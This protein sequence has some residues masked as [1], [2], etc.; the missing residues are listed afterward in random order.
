MLFHYFIEYPK[1]QEVFKKTNLAM[2]LE[3]TFSH[4]LSISDWINSAASRYVN[5]K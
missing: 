2:S 3:I 5:I 1:T 4:C